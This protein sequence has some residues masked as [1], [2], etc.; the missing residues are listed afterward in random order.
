[1]PTPTIDAALLNTLGTQAEDAQCVVPM[2]KPFRADVLALLIRE[3]QC[4]R[5][6]CN[7]HRYSV[8]TDKIIPGN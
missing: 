6:S 4:W 3:I 7:G 1:M 5:R 8:E 2:C